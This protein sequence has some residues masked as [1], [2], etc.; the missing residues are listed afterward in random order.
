MKLPLSFHATIRMK[1]F[2]E[3]KA[4]VYLE[5][6]LTGA[7]AQEATTQDIQHHSLRRALLWLNPWLLG[8]GFSDVGSSSPSQEEKP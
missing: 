1:E 2:Y 5:A 3:F 6:F 8:C 4:E 7:S